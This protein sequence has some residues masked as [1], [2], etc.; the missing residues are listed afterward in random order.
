M[1]SWVVAGFDEVPA[2]TQIVTLAQHL[3]FPAWGL[4]GGPANHDSRSATPLG[5]FCFPFD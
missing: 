4:D 1:N 3:L 2:D 5:Y